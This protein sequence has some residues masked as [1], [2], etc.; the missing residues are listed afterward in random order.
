MIFNDVVNVTLKEKRTVSGTA[1]FVTI[2]SGPVPGVVTFL[3]SGTTFDPAGGKTSSRLQIILSPFAFTIPPNAGSSALVMAWGPFTALSPEGAV[4]PHY[5][6]GRLH[7]YEM[8]AK[9]I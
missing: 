1:T 7:H 9:A 5:L 8:I 3:D 2:F 4:E 6:R